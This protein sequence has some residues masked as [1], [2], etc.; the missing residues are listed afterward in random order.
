MGLPPDQG[1][2]V[3]LSEH[4]CT[5]GQALQQARFH[6][7]YY[8][9]MHHSPGKRDLKKGAETLTLRNPQGIPAWAGRR[10]NNH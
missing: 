6:L 2:L 5:K 8:C 4:T 10:R 3:F 7:C 9:E 1:R